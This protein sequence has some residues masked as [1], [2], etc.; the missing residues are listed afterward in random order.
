MSR[1][2]GGDAPGCGMRS[3]G[4]RSHRVAASHSQ[5]GAVESVGIPGPQ[6]SDPGCTPGGWGSL[7]GL[8]VAAESGQ[9]GTGAAQT[10]QGQIAYRFGAAG[11]KGGRMMARAWRIALLA[12]LL[13]GAPAWA[14]AQPASGAHSRGSSAAVPWSALSARQQRLLES[15]RERWASLPP[16]RQR[17]LMRGSR[18]WLHLTPAQRRK[19]RQRFAKWRQMSPKQRAL[20]RSRWRQFQALPARQR[21]A[22]RSSF[23]AFERLP[24]GQRRQLRRRWRK[25]TPA[26]RQRMIERVRQR[27]IEDR[28]MRQMP[29]MPGMPG[30]GPRQFGSVPGGMGMPGG[31]PGGIGGGPR[32]GGHPPRR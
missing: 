12:L 20:L 17:A 6:R 23:H 21:A 29:G 7:D 19:A 32:R 2:G 28:Q 16:A 25:A 31:M 14:F 5:H 4:A 8:P 13:A 10:G 18:I 30:P 15:V 24:N 9:D 11:Q 1:C 26:Q 22:I 27:M 3:H